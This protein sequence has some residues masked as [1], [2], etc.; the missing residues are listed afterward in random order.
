[1]AVIN[2]ERPVQEVFLLPLN[3]DGSPGIPGEYVNLPPPSDPPYILRFEIGGTSSICRQG[4]LW[5]N[6]PKPG[7]DF[8][9]D[10]FQELKYDVVER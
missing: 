6:L 3:D 10:S 4:S 5:F 8:E 9:K 1:M 7:H 2:G